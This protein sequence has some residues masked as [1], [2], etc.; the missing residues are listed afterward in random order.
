MLQAEK[1]N[2]AALKPIKHFDGGWRDLLGSVVQLEALVA[3]EDSD[4]RFSG[5]PVRRRRAGIASQGDVAI[6]LRE[7]ALP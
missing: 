3:Q 4:G 5:L 1:S 7:P 2:K 6:A